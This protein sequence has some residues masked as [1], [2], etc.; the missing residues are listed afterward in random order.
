M[1][2]SNEDTLDLLIMKR[3]LRAFD[4]HEDFFK[5]SELKEI[6]DGFSHSKGIIQEHIIS[7]LKN[8]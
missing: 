5:L 4:N 8:L 6:V 3:N 1:D 7:Y 2:Y